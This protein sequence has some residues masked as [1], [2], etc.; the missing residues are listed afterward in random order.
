MRY[1]SEKISEKI[2]TILCSENFSEIRAVY[3]V[4]WK[5]MAVTYATIDDK[6][7]RRKDEICLLHI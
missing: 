5:N 4:V 3:Y 1:F 2:K 7:Q 6:T